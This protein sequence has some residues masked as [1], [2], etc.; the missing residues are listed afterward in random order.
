MVLLLVSAT[1]V[2]ATNAPRPGQSPVVQ[3]AS[4]PRTA[5]A[6]PAPQ[7]PPALAYIPKA[8]QVP[9]FLNPAPPVPG[10]QALVRGSDGNFWEEG[11]DGSAWNGWHSFAGPFV[12]APAIASWGPGRLD[13]FG[14]GTDRQLWHAW[15]DIGR[16]GGW[17]PLG[18][19]LASAPAVAAWGTQ[20]LDVLVR[21]SDDQ[22]WHKW[23][24]QGAWG[25][26]E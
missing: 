5:L 11:W 2:P 14:E 26:W 7:R 21:G 22:T 4:I 15:W 10:M 6:G 20:R 19:V 17:E 1:G 23:W 18:G 24:G 8:P 12:S 16:W 25:G 13:I 9:V 3:V